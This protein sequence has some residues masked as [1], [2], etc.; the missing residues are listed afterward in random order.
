MKHFNF[1]HLAALMAIM[2]A[3]VVSCHKDENP[4]VQDLPGK[5]F[6][7]SIT[8]QRDKATFD[9][10]VSGGKTV[11]PKETIQEL[12]VTAYN[13]VTLS[14]GGV[15]V[16]VSSSDPTVVGVEKVG[17]GSSSYRL[18]YRGGS[19]DNAKVSLVT[20]KVWNGTGAA[21]VSQRFTVKGIEAVEVTG[22]R[23]MWYECDK[24]VLSEVKYFVTWTGP[25]TYE[26]RTVKERRYLTYIDKE[27][28]AS[29]ELSFVPK[30]RE[31]SNGADV[32]SFEDIP[33]G[34]DAVFYKNYNEIDEDGVDHYVGNYY[35]GHELTFL[36]LEPEN[37]SFRT[38]LSFES[39]Y[40]MHNMHTIWK[41][42]GYCNGHEEGELAEDRMPGYPKRNPADYAWL[43]SK[44]VNK[45]VSELEG[46][47]AFLT[48]NSYS[49]EN[50][51]LAVVG[52]KSNDNST[53]YFAIGHN[54]T[55]DRNPE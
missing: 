7:I 33:F 44:T 46:M 54:R 28:V 47:K 17:S 32:V 45:D 31:L 41:D 14:T 3:A 1:L 4:A 30:M 55:Y 38:I 26:T 36:G 19:G 27:C 18:V 42:G 37:A 5:T 29:H 51:Y 15:E 25:D 23:Y 22:L 10:S 16:N 9:W 43:N 40:D 2:G 11:N 34:Y 48:N 35:H 6:S 12:C 8:E 21:E 24:S 50:F 49:G 13:T 39:E 20:I 53:K 52:V